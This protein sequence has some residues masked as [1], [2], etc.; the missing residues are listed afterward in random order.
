M[1]FTLILTII[2]FLIQN[3]VSNDTRLLFEKTLQT[4]SGKELL[5]TLIAGNITVSTWPNSEVNIK[6]YGNDEAE[7]K[8]IFNAENTET[9]VKV[10]ATKK[11][12]K[13]FKNLNIKVEV[14]VPVSYNAR[15]FSSGGNLKVNDLNGK[16]EANTSGGN[17]IADNINGN[18]EA[19]TSGGNV[20]IDKNMGNIDAS[21]AGGN[22]T[23]ESFEGNVNVST[24]GGHVTLTGSNGKVDASTAGGNIN[25][26]YSGKNLG[27][28]LSTMGGNITANLPSDFDAD[29][30]IG[31]LAGRINCD[32][33]E[34]ENKNKVTNHLKAKFN[35]G[36]ELF[37][38]TTSAGNIVIVKK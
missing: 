8:V 18:V 7:D 17:I 22:I 6:V 16:V 3:A 10:E 28:E 11:G 9:G 29:A 1:K 30:E 4:E 21:T 26:D 20:I 12:T 19:Y 38:C 27:M 37:K 32:F 15:L 35:S 25:V 24:M 36:G 33:A 23:V 13:N 5:V 14:I 34:V 2:A 31:T